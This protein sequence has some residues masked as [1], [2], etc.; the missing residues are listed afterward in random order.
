MTTTNQS[1]PQAFIAV[2][3]NR[4]KIYSDEKIFINSGTEFSIELFNPTQDVVAAKVYLN[5]KS[6]SERMLVI[7]PGERSFLERFIDDNKKFVFETYEVANTTE[8]KTAIANNGKIRVEFFKERKPVLQGYNQV[9]NYPVYVPYAPLINPYPTYPPYYYG[10]GGSGIFHNCCTTSSAI[11]ATTTTT[12]T[13]GLTGS[14]STARG[15]TGTV[16]NTSESYTCNAVGDKGHN[17]HDE[18]ACMDSL[19]ETGRVEA[20]ASSNQHFGTY[21]GDFDYFY[22]WCVDYHLMPESNKPVEIN[23]LREYC[24]GC[25]TRIRKSSWH[26]CPAC[27]ETLD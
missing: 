10:T 17:V 9:I 3:R 22:S 8:V 26:F 14:T 5:D 2:G 7:K 11:G 6:I 21:N 16:S 12:T 4:M 1:S 23:K 27:G 13:G 20:G 25:R 15:L 18:A 24:P 19:M